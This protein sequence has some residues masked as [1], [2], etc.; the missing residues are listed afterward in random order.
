MRHAHDIAIGIAVALGRLS[1]NDIRTHVPYD[2]PIPWDVVIV[3]C[4]ARQHAI[5]RGPVVDPQ[6]RCVTCGE[7]LT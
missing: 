5:D 3:T 1:G 2:P 4:G 7:Q 6:Q